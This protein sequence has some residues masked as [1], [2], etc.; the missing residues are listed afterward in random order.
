[1]PNARAHDR[2]ALQSAV[3]LAPLSAA[4][5]LSLDYPPEQV[6]IGTAL[7]VGT[8]LACS[9]WLSP[10]L[11]LDSAV[12]DRWGSLRLIWLPYRRIVPH[13]HWFSHS[14]ISALLR[15][16]YLVLMLGGL[17]FLVS[18]FVPG[19]SDSVA[20]WLSDMVRTYPRETAL[21]ALG[22][23]IS[24]L[25]HTTT[26]YLYSLRVRVLRR[27]VQRYGRRRGR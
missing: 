22:A 15:I 20:A 24:D 6:T 23:V 21:I 11:D 14:G 10:D 19:A 2:I 18:F 1:M 27:Q 5:L 4:A 8:H 25:V 13:R 26:D 17:L 16:V 7:L 9:H 12:D 3:V